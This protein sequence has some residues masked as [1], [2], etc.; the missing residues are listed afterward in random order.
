[1]SQNAPQQ[2]PHDDQIE[3]RW[4]ALQERC[5]AMTGKTMLDLD[6][7]ETM[8]VVNLF[9]TDDRAFALNHLQQFSRPSL[10]EHLRADSWTGI[11]ARNKPQSRKREEKFTLKDAFSYD[12]SGDYARD[13]VKGILAVSYLL[14]SISRIGNKPVDGRI[15]QGLAFALQE[16]AEDASRYLT[17]KSRLNEAERALE[18]ART[19]A[20]L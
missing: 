7:D 17:E 19:E 9:S 11:K 14:D 18:K 4:K 8:R 13:T 10:A 5:I 2:V 3:Q 1:V 12:G 6:T 20:G 16:I 15:A